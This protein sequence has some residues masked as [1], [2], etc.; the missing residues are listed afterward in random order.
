M[1]VAGAAAGGCAGVAIEGRAFLKAVVGGGGV[2]ASPVFVVDDCA[3]GAT[4]D[5][6][7]ASGAGVPE[8]GDVG[9]CSLGGAAPASCALAFGV[10]TNAATK[11]A[12]DSVNIFLNIVFLISR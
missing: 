6:L 10:K 11:K 1:G 5:K 4:S 2:T 9:T 8:T 7:A 3:G 12:N